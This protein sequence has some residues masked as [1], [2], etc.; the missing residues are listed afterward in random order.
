MSDALA[1]SAHGGRY[2]VKSPVCECEEARERESGR[3]FVYLMVV[4]PAHSS[5]VFPTQ[6]S[7]SVEQQTAGGSRVETSELKVRTCP[8]DFVLF[9]LMK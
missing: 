1:T 9:L 8:V 5:A 4:A 2:I 3:V 7:S 6:V